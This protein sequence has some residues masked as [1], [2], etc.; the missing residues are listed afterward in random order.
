V[1]DNIDRLKY[2]FELCQQNLRASIKKIEDAAKE[3]R[4]G[5]PYNIWTDFGATSFDECFVI[6]DIN[7]QIILIDTQLFRLKDIRN[8]TL[9]CDRAVNPEQELKNVF[10]SILTEQE[11]YM[12]WIIKL[13]KNNHKIKYSDDELYQLKEIAQLLSNLDRPSLIPTLMDMSNQLYLSTQHKRSVYEL[14]EKALSLRSLLIHAIDPSSDQQP[15]IKVVLDE[16]QELL[17]FGV[18]TLNSLSCEALT[19]P[20]A[21]LDFL[22]SF[23]RRVAALATEAGAVAVT[24]RCLLLK[25][26]YDDNH[27]SL[28]KMVSEI[29]NELKINIVLN[30]QMIDD[31]AISEHLA[32]SI[33]VKVESPVLFQQPVAASA[34]QA[35]AAPVEL[36]AEEQNKKASFV[37]LLK[38]DME[39]IRKSLYGKSAIRDKKYLA[40]NQLLT[41]I[42]ENENTDIATVI[43]NF[44]NEPYG[45]ATNYDL[46][47][48]QRFTCRLF[49]C[50]RQSKTRSQELLD[51]FCPDVTPANEV[52]VNVTQ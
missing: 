27:I 47:K 7:K 22:I 4:K 21:Y 31:R 46:I 2:G 35:I 39:R 12:Q 48:Q 1:L 42:N 38:I 52:K 11:S 17:P 30:Y 8:S 43:N 16:L 9:N 26:Q 28:T 32:K 15:P 20:N 49:S 51:R 44:K 10:N 14:I 3:R 37:A 25:K 13:H 24:K 36:S 45:E 41:N 29:A 18:S 40:L 33:A 6:N 5:Q 50:F 19:N 34:L 23:P